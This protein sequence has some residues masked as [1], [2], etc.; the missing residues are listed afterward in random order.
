MDN[1]L[2]AFAVI[3]GILSGVNLFLHK[4]AANRLEETSLG[5]V[6]RPQ[7]LTQLLRNPYVYLVLV[8]G[9]LVLALDLA[10]LSNRVPGI[11]GLN[12]I[13][14]LGNVLF[15]LLSIAILGEKIDLRI[16]AGIGFGIL[17]LILLSRA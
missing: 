8:M 11:V 3:A 5:E 17:A 13:I 12:F 15:A 6:L 1:K 7:F 16:G 10:F 2:L 14:V 4:V 9:L